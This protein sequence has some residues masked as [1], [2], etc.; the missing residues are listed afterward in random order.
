MITA[1][2]VAAVLTG[3]PRTP[4][5]VQGTVS[6]GAGDPVSGASVTVLGSTISAV[7]DSSGKYTLHVVEAGNYRISF[8]RLGYRSLSVSVLL[9]GGPP[10]RVDV[11]LE[12][13]AVTLPSVTVLAARSPHGRGYPDG[14]HEP[15]MWHLSHAALVASP[16]LAYSDVFGALAE[17]PAVEM[18]PELPAAV[19][20]R[21]GS[22]DQNLVLLDG[23]PTEN[24]VHAADVFSGINPDA[25]SGVSV[26][27]GAESARYGGSLAGLINITTIDPAVSRVTT[28]GTLSSTMAGA[29]F[30]APVQRL[31]GGVVFG[32]RH[33]YASVLPASISGGGDGLSLPR[34]HD[35]LAKATA[36]LAGN[37]LSVLMLSTADQFGFNALADQVGASTSNSVSGLSGAFQD[38]ATAA[39]SATL[40]NRF[41]WSTSIA[42][43]G[44]SRP[45]AAGV[46]ETHVWRSASSVHADWSAYNGPVR[47]ANQLIRTGGSGEVSLPVRGGKLSGG[48]QLERIETRYHVVSA[49]APVSSLLH[50]DSRPWVASAFLQR[51][52]AIGRW[53]ASAGVRAQDV[54]GAGIQLEPRLSISRT[55][56]GGVEASVGYARSHQY[57]QSL[58]NEESILDAVIGVNLPVAAG[59]GAGRLPVAGADAVS[60]NITVPVTGSTR[61]M[62]EAY[63]RRMNHLVLVAP[64]TSEAFAMSGFR[65]GTGMATGGSATLVHDGRLLSWDATTSMLS[66]RRTAGSVSYRPTFAPSFSGSMGA[67]YHWGALT[68]LRIA[69]WVASGRRTTPVAG[70]FTWDWQNALASHREISGSPQRYAA[71]IGSTS[72]PAYTRVDVGFRREIQMGGRTN[73]SV[74]AGIQNVFGVHNAFGYSFPDPATPHSL[75]MMPRSLTFGL[76][77]RR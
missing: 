1:L 11:S 19:H 41:N 37:N 13:M 15:G 52:W 24:A 23:I 27:G 73:L 28:T 49:T 60:A 62:L 40:Q 54:D 50:F 22:G 30:A 72:L 63:S 74:F 66:V 34:W 26:G 32:L 38:A 67:T 7:T 53:G 48:I 43:V 3:G 68:R 76:D 12:P 47:L 6:T 77:W 25:V 58:R 31:G 61:L 16:R 51:E 70:A 33:N 39:S 65:I 14:Y 55:F 45:I 8:S 44:L 69:A 10:V 20:I 71:P 57:L 4:S 46:L 36:K 17:V 42:G 64:T 29:L 21:G 35:M 18:S 59:P 56:P 2:L 9:A 5:G 75:G